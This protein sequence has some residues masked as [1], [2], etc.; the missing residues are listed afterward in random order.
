MENIEVKEWPTTS[1]MYIRPLFDKRFQ[2]SD[3]FVFSTQRGCYLV[4][5]ATPNKNMVDMYQMSFSDFIL[6]YN[7]KN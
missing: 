1:K 7:S 5:A 3:L 6:F 2:S 4:A